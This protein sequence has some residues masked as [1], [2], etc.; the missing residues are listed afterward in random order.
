[1]HEMG[2]LTTIMRTKLESIVGQQRTNDQ[3]EHATLTARMVGVG[4][5]GPGRERLP[6]RLAA[7]INYV[8]KGPTSV[9]MESSDPH[10]LTTASTILSNVQPLPVLA[11]TS[12][13]REHGRDCCRQKK[14]SNDLNLVRRDQMMS[15]LA[16]QDQVRFA[17]Q[18]SPHAMAWVHVLPSTGLHTMI[19]A[20]DFKC[21]LRWHLGQPVAHP[22]P[23]R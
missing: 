7:L 17:S 16:S 10:E 2:E 4:I 13:I 20:E 11:D 5:R 12:L 3:G 21:L 15:T 23:H 8:S 19:P 1:M 22:T 9:G 14:W 18:L 6:A